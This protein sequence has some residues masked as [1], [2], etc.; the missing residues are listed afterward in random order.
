MTGKTFPRNPQLFFLAE[1]P[2]ENED[3]EDAPVSMSSRTKLGHVLARNLFEASQVQLTMP[4]T[5]VLFVLFIAG[6][7]EKKNTV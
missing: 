3:P 2:E 4:V 1:K 5:Q 7:A 6:N